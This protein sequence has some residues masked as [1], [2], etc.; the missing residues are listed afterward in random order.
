MGSRALGWL[1][2]HRWPALLLIDLI[3]LQITFS[4]TYTLRFDTGMFTNPLRPDFAPVA[5]ALSLYWIIL[6]ALLGVYNRKVSTSRYE[7]IL[8]LVKPILIGLAIL[9]LQSMDTGDPFSS[10]RLVLATYGLLLLLTTGSAHI[11]FRTL[12]RW[13]YRRRIGLY[14]SL[15]IGYGKRGQDLV[16]ALSV[17]PIFGHTVQAVVYGEADEVPSGDIPSYPLEKLEELLEGPLG[18]GLEYVL[19]ALEPEQRESALEIVD[20][21]H[22][23]SLHVMIVPDFF[24]ILVGLAKSR[25][26]YGVPLLEV[27]PDL[28]DPTSRLIKRTMDIAA[29]IVM[30]TDPLQAEAN[31]LPVERVHT[32][33]I[34]QHVCGCRK[35]NRRGV[36]QRGRSAHHACGQ[37]PPLQ[38]PR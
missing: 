22:R 13:A 9:F 16:K 12:I 2:R 14:R 26:L 8:E 11:F 28:L 34:P 7:A 33:Q 5:L 4:L 19:V 30:L 32:G 23:Y 29:G 18:E 35:E 6:F 36:G 38:P 21:V 3:A 15:V 1:I 20:R 25:E 10:S 27:F 31:R 17:R 24:Q 37:I